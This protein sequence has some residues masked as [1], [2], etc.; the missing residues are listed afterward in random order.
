MW[1]W[2]KD[3]AF[4]PGL[5]FCILGFI[6]LLTAVEVARATS[7]FEPN[8]LSPGMAIGLVLFGVGIILCCISDEL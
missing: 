7:D 4:W 3:H 1:Q 5:F 2:I 6:V 8:T